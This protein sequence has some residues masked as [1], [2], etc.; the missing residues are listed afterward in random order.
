MTARRSN[1]TG[2]PASFLAGVALLSLLAGVTPGT[3]QSPAP[4]ATASTVNFSFDQVDI[5]TFVKLI[6]EMTGRRFAVDEAVKGQISVVAPRIA[7]DQVYPLFV[8]IL[9]SAGCSVVEEDGLVRVVLLPP[10]AFPSAP[11]LGPAGTLPPGGVVTRVIRLQHTSV[12]DLKKV[13]DAITGREKSANVAV[14]EASNHLIITDTAESVRRFEQVIAEID[15]PGVGSVSEVVFLKHVDA[16]EF[17]QQYNAA[18]ASR[19]R[20]VREGVVVKPGHDLILLPAP[21]CNGIVMVGTSADI[22][23]VKKILT[24]IDVES[25]S[26]QGTLHAIFLKYIGA[27]DASKNLNALL[28]KSLGK[29][30]P[31]AGDRRRIAIES[32]PASNALLVDASPL[33]FQLINTLVAE[34]DRMPQQVLIEVTIA[35]ISAGKSLDVNVEMAS[36]AL[37]GKVGSTVLSGGSTLSDSTES[38]MTA[39]Q[40]G[41]LPR[42]ITVGVAHGTRLDA[43]G[44]VVASYPAAFNIN[45]LQ[46]NSD[47]KILSSVPLVAQNN[48]EASVSVVQNIPI[49]KS[50]IQ[51]GSGTA[52][53]VIQNIDRLDVGIKLK[54]TPHIN[55]DNEVCMALNPSI[56]AIIAAGTTGTDYTPTIARREVSTTVTVPSGRTI[57]IS[58]LVSENQ[59]KTVQGIPYLS[60]IPLIG[61]LFRHTVD[62]KERTNLII[63]VTPR[64][65]SD[66]AMAG[67]AT[68][69]A[70]TDDWGHR[71]GL[72]TN[73]TTGATGTVAGA[74]SP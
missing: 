35:E 51:G 3:A 34:L 59:T 15:K 41:I 9:E 10:R 22:E 13:L 72:G 58:G 18:A 39:I 37:P 60:A 5:R 27:E 33:D 17:V 26:G 29:D 74:V 40:S 23:D 49:L 44:N 38:L 62:S 6:G 66:A 65:M 12:T 52:R 48:K 70:I 50:T 47:V 45:A 63:F 30:P 73:L 19:E 28:E 55:P 57:V 67:T 8:K 14:L 69:G 36:L 4:A 11:V 68:P 71:T 46:Q 24:L 53:D 43:S 16:A 31:K 2:R 7:V 25:S 21:Q 56:E 32:S 54:L 1:R 64:V 42:G 61:W 20:I